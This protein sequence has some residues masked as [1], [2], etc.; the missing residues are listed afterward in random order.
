LSEIFNK[1]Y[2]LLAKESE[3]KAMDLVQ[4]AHFMRRATFGAKLTELYD[5]TPPEQ[6]LATWLNT[7]VNV[8]VPVIAPLLPAGQRGPQVAQ[9]NRWLLQQMVEAENPLHER[10]VG[11]WRDHF[12]VSVRELNAAQ[13]LTDYEERLRTHALGDFKE[14]LWQVTISPAMLS[15][16]NNGQNR[17]GN[18][19]ENFSR[20]VM[21]L[22]TIGPGDNG[23]NYTENDVQQGARALTGWRIISETEAGRYTS[24]FTP[25]RHDTGV[26][27]FLGR[28]GNWKPED[29]IDILANHPETGKF[30]ARKLWNT[31]V[32][33]N[34]EPEVI[35]PIAAAYEQSNRSIAAMVEAV[36]TSPEFYSEKAYRSRMSTPLEFIIGTMRH[37]ELTANYD[38]V[39]QG[40]RAMGQPIYAPP[41]VKGWPDNWLSAPSLI[42]RLNLSREMTRQYVNDNGFGYEPN[43]YSIQDLMQLLLDENNVN[44]LPINLDQLSDREQA[45]VILSSPPYQFV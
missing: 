28:T 34:P 16:L 18:I 40:L 14:L 4:K 29:I 30:L 31:F 33:S 41:T 12:I 10:I 43:H 19:N 39:I 3:G 15:Y 25:S 35:A 5:A 1:L 24:R 26:K 20:E 23:E 13:Y 9:F 21:E 6:L 36:F 44:N 8:S 7:P 27:T 22:F 11:F 17:V 32:Y 37:L 42:S 2:N 38:R 45:A